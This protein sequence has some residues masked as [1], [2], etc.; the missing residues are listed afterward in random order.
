MSDTAGN[1]ESLDSLTVSNACPALEQGL[2]MIKAGQGV[3]DLEQ[4]TVVDSV[5]VAVLLAWQRAAHEAGG[6]LRFV[7]VPANLLTL[8]HL[9][10]V[11]TLLATAPAV[12][13][14]TEATTAGTTA[15]PADAPHQ[16]H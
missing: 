8:A 4:L 9:Y 1:F 2:A 5:A 16:H 14:A 6:A 13:A 7:N 11:D 12:A 3:F 15:A 10:G